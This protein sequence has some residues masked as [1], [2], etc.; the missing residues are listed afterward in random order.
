LFYFVFYFNPHAFSVLHAN[1]K[2]KQTKA[3]KCG[4]KCPIFA[5]LRKGGTVGNNVEKQE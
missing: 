4:F 2:N 3:W 5:P 1:I